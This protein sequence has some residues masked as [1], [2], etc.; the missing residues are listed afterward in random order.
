MASTKFKK[1]IEIINVTDPTKTIQVNHGF[2][3]LK[4]E[5]QNLTNNVK[6]EAYPGVG[7]NGAIK[8]IA[9]GTRSVINNAVTF[10]TTGFSVAA[11]LADINDTAGE[12]LIVEWEE[13]TY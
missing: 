9:D 13:E 3:V 1:A 4:A 10:S 7:T 5:I 8:T 12:Q 2:G 6:I 11:S